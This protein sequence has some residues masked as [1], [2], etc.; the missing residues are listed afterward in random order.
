MTSPSLSTLA[1]ELQL[2]IFTSLDSFVDVAALRR[3]SQQF[4][5]IWILHRTNISSAV[6]RRAIDCLDDAQDFLDM[7]ERFTVNR[8]EVAPRRRIHRL[9]RNQEIAYDVCRR[10]E[11]DC[12]ASPEHNISAFTIISS[13][14]RIQFL[15]CYYRFQTFVEMCP[16]SR[17]ME[18]L[19][20]RVLMEPRFSS[21]VYI[22]L[23][24]AC[25]ERWRKRQFVWE[26]AIWQAVDALFES[27]GRA[28]TN[29]QNSPLETRLYG[30][31][32]EFLKSV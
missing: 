17:R 14:D 24:S 2:A 16:L 15:R 13:A 25:D 18:K 20:N 11:A 26:A 12:K 6:L 4:H 3:T 21:Q 7:Q 1:P 30:K 23:K 31:L 19:V 32:L 22:L 28:C 10:F 29:V 27:I 5:A 9:F 8:K